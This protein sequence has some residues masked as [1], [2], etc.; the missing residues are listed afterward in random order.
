MVSLIKTKLATIRSIKRSKFTDVIK[1]QCN[2]PSLHFQHVFNRKKEVKISDE[3]IEWCIGKNIELV[4]DIFINKYN[5]KIVDE[6]IDDGGFVQDTYIIKRT[7][8]IYD[9]YVDLFYLNTDEIVS[10]FSIEINN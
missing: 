4:T 1:T 8:E 2:E 3:E 7:Y 6:K 10:Y 9:V 5:S